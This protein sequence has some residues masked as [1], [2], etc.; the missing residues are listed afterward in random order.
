MF[1]IYVCC[2]R[3]HDAEEN[4]NCVAS[5]R[6]R[7][8]SPYGTPEKR[9]NSEMVFYGL[10]ESYKKLVSTIHK[11]DLNNKKIIPC[12]GGGT[13]IIFCKKLAKKC[14]F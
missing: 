12:T 11:V 6:A 2:N 4:W 5:I 7:L 14:H 1:G 13:V 8:I 9:P 10:G 3:E